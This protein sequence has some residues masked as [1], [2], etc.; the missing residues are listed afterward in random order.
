MEH[1]HGDWKAAP[2]V[3]LRGNSVDPLEYV[4]KAGEGGQGGVRQANTN[5]EEAKSTEVDPDGPP[6]DCLRHHCCEPA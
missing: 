1:V 2:P 6:G 4:G 5:P 3:V